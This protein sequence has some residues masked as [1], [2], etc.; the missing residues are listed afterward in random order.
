VAYFFRR[1]YALLRPG[2]TFGLIATNTIAQGDTRASGL[3]PIRNA[4]GTIYRATRRVKWPG[5]AAVVVS[6]VHVRKG[7]V[8]GPAWLD[9]REVER[10]TAYLFH[11]GGDEDPA[12]L[13]ANSGQSFQ[14]TTL[15]GMGFTFDDG[16]EDASP[17]P[18][19]ERLIG[20][21]PRNGERIFPFLGGR[22][23]N[24]SPVHAPRRHVIDFGD[25]TLEE[26]QR[27]PALVRLVEEKVRPRREAGSK[28]VASWPW[29]RFW[30]HRAELYSSIQGLPRVLVQARV[31]QMLATTWLPAGYVF[32]D[33][34]I[35]FALPVDHALALLQSRPHEIW[36]RFFGS[37]LEDRL[38][39]TPTDCY[40]T[41]PFPPNWQTNPTLEAAGAA[42]HTHR[43]ALMVANDQGLT[44]TYN[45]F[46]DPDE[47][48]PGILELRRLHD[49]MDRAVLDAYGWKDLTPTCEFLLDHG[50]EADFTGRRRAP[51]RYRWPDDVHDEVL[52]RLLALNAQRARDEALAGGAGQLGLGFGD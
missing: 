16:N 12:R 11:D 36:A 50:T 45:R 48:D 43:A 3:R 29:W 26:A 52:A 20:E 41:F 40:E 44:A 51:W 46:H 31:S 19:M 35:I 30:R 17:L 7:A 6:V 4:G 39:Y 18:E 37:S 33:Q 24:E 25:M 1:A 47:L 8:A 42:Y 22:E 34:L 28:E 9:G 10:I 21:D 27:W 13:R 32:S 49:A 5:L 38:R 15:L 2:G 23:V 14:G